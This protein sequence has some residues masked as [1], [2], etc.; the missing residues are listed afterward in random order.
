[1]GLDLP[2]KRWHALALEHQERPLGWT[3]V[4]AHWCN[5]AVELASVHVLQAL[6]GLCF[7][8]L[9]NLHRMRQ[10]PHRP[11]CGCWMCSD[12]EEECM[13]EVQHVLKRIMAQKK[14]AS[15]KK[16]AQIEQ[17]CHPWLCAVLQKPGERLSL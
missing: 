3:G 14:A 11:R 9:L 6:L 4:L 15:R 12:D 8:S 16:I 1:M 7:A 2:S 10:Y 5:F 17:V 13:E